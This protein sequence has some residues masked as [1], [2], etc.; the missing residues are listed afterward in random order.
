MGN[1]RAKIIGNL[2]SNLIRIFPVLDL[3]NDVSHSGFL[4]FEH[5]Q[6]LTTYSSNH[7]KLIEKEK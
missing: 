2:T 1:A 7:W 6:M 5:I 4:F 3:G